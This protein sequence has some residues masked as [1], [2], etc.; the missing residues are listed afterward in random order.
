MSDTDLPTLVVI[1]GQFRSGTSAVAQVVN[2][3][4]V[5]VAAVIGCPHIYSHYELDW[6]DP[7]TYVML[8][9]HFPLDGAEV[10]KDGLVERIQ[11]DLMRRWDI[12]RSLRAAAKL[13]PPMHL[14]TKCPFWALCLPELRQAAEGLFGKIVYIRTHRDPSQVANSVRRVY[15]E[16]AIPHV[17]STNTR[18][19][20]C[21]APQAWDLVVPLEYLSD[22]PKDTVDL[23]AK[24]VGVPFNPNAAA[25]VRGGVA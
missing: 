18:I 8:N 7:F 14:A 19:L 3:L 10:P 20:A 21:M 22:H 16:E 25:L 12:H 24:A 13:P 4:G 2:R 6:E 5:S 11:R 17:L 15:P 23:I 1:T 9:R